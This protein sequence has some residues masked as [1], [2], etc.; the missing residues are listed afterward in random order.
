MTEH[1]Q[2]ILKKAAA[3]LT[4][5]VA[6]FTLTFGGPGS[7]PVRAAEEIVDTSHQE[8]SYEETVQDLIQLQQQYPGLVTAGLTSTTSQGRAI[9]LVILGN[10]NAANR[11]LVTASIH[12]REYITTPLVMKLIEEYASRAATGQVYGNG[13]V[14]YQDLLNETCFVI[15]PIANPDGVAISQYGVNGAVLPSTRHWVSLYGTKATQIKANANGVDINRNFPTG[16]IDA[17]QHESGISYSPSL[18]YYKGALPGSEAETQNL[19]TIAATFPSLMVVN[20]HTQGDVIYYSSSETSE[21]NY[22]Q[23]YTLVSLAQQ[24]TGYQPM[25]SRLSRANG[26]WADYYIA[27]YQKPSITIE[28]GTQNPVP[29]SQFPAIWQNNKELWGVLLYA[30]HIGAFR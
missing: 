20:Y 30:V 1:R 22:L 13:D 17:E 21:E 18:E 24:V 7:L 4:G 6:A 5:S 9:P 15:V 16:W 10:V 19:M 26:T 11:I 3:A 27:T 2:S 23:N 29:V 28:V 25:N 14:S 8:Y 12:A